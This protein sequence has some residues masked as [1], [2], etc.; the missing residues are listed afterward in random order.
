MYSK[1]DISRHMTL[2]F[3]EI[4]DLIYKGMCIRN[5]RTQNWLETQVPAWVIGVKPLF[6]S[7]FDSIQVL[8]SFQVKSQILFILEVELK[9][10]ALFF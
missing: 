6:V 1:C 2:N 3:S 4:N 8:N 5:M 9:K 7:V 10:W